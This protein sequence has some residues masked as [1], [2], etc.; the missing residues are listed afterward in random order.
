MSAK[1]RTLAIA[2]NAPYLGFA[3]FNGPQRL[4]V[5]GI[6]A[7]AKRSDDNDLSIHLQDHIRR[8]I[9]RFSPSVIAINGTV[10]HTRFESATLLRVVKEET[11]SGSIEV[12][13]VKDE[14]IRSSFERFTEPTRFSMAAW[15]TLFF[16][17]LT[18]HFL[19][20]QRKPQYLGLF[21][22]VSLGIGYMSRFG[23]YQLTL[24]AARER[25][26]LHA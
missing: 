9:R 7:V 5:S 18:A 6:R 2:W 19:R 3:V 24:S 1:S 21:D 4:R 25:N 8:L 14:E 10:K 20:L 26:S 11:S 16:P 15:A 23:D 22:A 12:V 17:K 13:T